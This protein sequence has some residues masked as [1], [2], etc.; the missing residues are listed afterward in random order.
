MRLEREIYMEKKDSTKAKRK[1]D[2]QWVTHSIVVMVA[3]V[4]VVLF[5]YFAALWF[6]FDM[7]FAEIPDR[8]FTTY[9]KIIPVWC[10]ITVVVFFA[11]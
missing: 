3:D 1:P 5:S 6:R 7:H 2:M 9:L 8:Y 4:L 11:S 10:V